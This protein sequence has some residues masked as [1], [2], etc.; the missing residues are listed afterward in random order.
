MLIRILQLLDQAEL[1]C[2][3]ERE[4]APAR[5]KAQ[6]PGVHEDYVQREIHELLESEPSGV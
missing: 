2:A 5:R 3:L 1:E 4:A 6:I